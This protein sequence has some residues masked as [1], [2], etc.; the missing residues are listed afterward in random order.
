MKPAATQ[1]SYTVWYKN[2]QDFLTLK[3]EWEDLY[4]DCPYATPFQ[5]WEWLYSWWESYGEGYELRLVAVWNSDVLVGVIP[6]MLVRSWGF[7]RLLFVGTGI[8]DYL[9][10]LV[11]EGWEDIVAEAG[12]QALHQMDDWHVA[13]LQEMRPEAAA[14]SIFRKWHGFRA[15]VW[16]SSCTVTDAKP[17]DEVLMSLSKKQRSNTRRAIRRTEADNVVCRLAGVEDARQA[18]HRFIDLHQ[19]LWTGREIAPE[20][21]SREFKSHVLAATSR[22]TAGRLGGMSEYWKDGEVVASHLLVFGHNF[23]AEY[24]TGATQEARRRYSLHP[25]YMWNLVNVARSRDSSSVHLLRGEEPYKLQWASIVLANHRMI[26]GRSLLWYGIYSNYYRLRTKV[27]QYV[28]S[29]KAPQWLKDASNI[30]LTL[31]RKITRQITPGDTT[32]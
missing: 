17:W 28:Y 15:D 8:T 13:D 27:R 32:Q 5:S 6:L 11:R 10:V 2:A 24:L 23:V 3:E 26:L 9:D 25:L 12:V 29:D 22:L 19:K 14:W 16:Q 1:P 21:L 20:H 18:A 4:K 7:G 30:R 31:R